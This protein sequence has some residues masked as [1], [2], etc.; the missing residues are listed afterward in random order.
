MLGRD[1]GVATVIQ[2]GG[3]FSFNINDGAHEFLFVGVSGNPNTRA[4]YQM[5]GGVLDMNGKVLGIA[6]GRI[7]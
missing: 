3:T 4:T 5:N 2:N 6:L 1:G 7:P